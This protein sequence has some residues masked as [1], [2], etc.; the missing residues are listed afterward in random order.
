MNKKTKLINEIANVVFYRLQKEILHHDKY[1][2]QPDIRKSYKSLQ[3]INEAVKTKC[4]TAGAVYQTQI[5]EN[6][7]TVNIKIPFNLDLNK[8]EAKLLEDNIH[9]VLEL[10]LAPHF[11]KKKK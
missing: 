6:N 4:Q 8:S 9:N 3:Q 5:T 2:L 7:I 11:L 1:D 10:V